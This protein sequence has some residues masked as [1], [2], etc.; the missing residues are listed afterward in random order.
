MAKPIGGRAGALPTRDQVIAF[1]GGAAAPNGEKPPQRVTKRDIA[2][3]FGVKG[4]AKTELKLLIKD[5]ENEGS[6]ARGRKALQ[7]QGRLPSIVVADIAARDRDG[8]LIAKPAEW[9]EE[10]PPPRILVR[11]PRG[12]RDSAPA[13]ALGARVLMRVEFDPD[14]SGAEPAYSGRVIKILDK[15]K[16]RVFA[17]FR[18]AADGSG[19]ALP[20]EKRAAR[21][22]MVP[23]NLAGDAEDG[24]LVAI[25]PLREGRFGLPNAR[26][27]EFLGSVKSERAVSLIALAQHHIPHVFSPAALKEA[28]AA[29]PVRLAPP[30]EDWRSLPLVTIDPPDA[31]DHDDAVHATPDPDPANPG[32]FI[33]TVAIANVVGYVR[34][35]SAL[36]RDALERGNSVY[37]PDRVVPMLPERISNDLCSLR[38]L[39]DRPALA[40]RIILGANGR[41]HAH[42]FHRI[43]MRSAAKLSY[44]QAQAAIDGRPDETTAPLLDSVLKP[45]Y[46]AHSVIRIERERRDPLDLDLPER[47]LILDNNGRLAGVRWPERLEAHRLIEEFMILANVAAAETLEAQHSPLL[48]RAHDAPSAEKLNDL[49]EFFEHHRRQAGARRPCAAGAFQRGFEPRARAGGRGP[50]QRGRAARPGAGRVQP[51]ELRPFRPQPAPLR[52]FHLAD[53][54]LCR[55]HRPPRADPRPQPR[56]GRP[57]RHARRASWRR[58][59]SIFRPPN[60]ARWRRSARR[61]TG[62]W[63]PISRTGSAPCSRRGS[64]ASPGSACSSN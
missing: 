1:I 41:K 14:A 53:P 17:V 44:E 4:E 22:F 26:V 18:R 34:P 49:V 27:V 56:R 11:R 57:Q 46:A 3:A 61:S 28:E 23:M 33:V 32:G 19:R 37:F 62:W 48:Y 16:A 42:V 45:L 64:P 55:P 24:D 15:L 40:V 10:T 7:V 5:L 43:M 30:R 52:P 38:P 29:R 36:D 50:G 13:P 58:S 39:E 31:K 60:G 59:P 12:K 54:P 51:R 25:E 47:K 35:G 21:E 8:E 20:V 9:N 63:L 6:I 2:R